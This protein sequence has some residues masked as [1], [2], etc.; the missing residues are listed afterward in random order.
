MSLQQIAF[1]GQAPAQRSAIYQQN[2]NQ[3]IINQTYGGTYQHGLA[4]GQTLLIPAGQWVV[5]AGPYSTV[6]FFDSASQI[7]KNLS[8]YDTVPYPVSSDGTNF[9]FANLTGC[10]VGAVVTNAGT[11]GSLPVSMF[12]PTG[13]WTGGFFTAQTTPSVTCTASAG[14]STWNTFIG[15]AISTT[16]TVTAGGSG[17]TVA[18]KLLIVPPASQGNQPF[19]PAT[20]ICTISGGAINAVT[21]T[22]QGAGYVAAPTILILNQPGDTTG[23]GAV[24]TPTL[25]GAGQVTA[26]LQNTSG[27]VLTS[28]PT[29]TIGGTSAPASAA[30]TA[31]MNFSITNA[32]TGTVT[33]GAGYTNGY[34]LVATGGIS[35]ATPVFTNPAIEKGI[36][37]PTQPNIF[38]SQTTVQNLNSANTIFAFNGWGFQAVPLALTAV[39]LF[40]TQGLITAPTVGGVNDVCQLYPI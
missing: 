13:Q 6:Q 3:Q 2:A 39:G 15:G 21:V 30:A 16:V 23:A 26:V 29:L 5:Q 33:A 40:T 18:P 36:I 1:P 20:A 35:T 7:W 11:A 10:P 22:N 24:L 19:I 25:T 28:V 8:V 14:G 9:R 27:T 34:T 12:T 38:S 31:L 32:G 17:Y 37:Y 4:P